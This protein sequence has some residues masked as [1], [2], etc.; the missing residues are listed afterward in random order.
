MKTTR[1]HDITLAFVIVFVAVG[2][3]AYFATNM[4]TSSKASGQNRL[5]KIKNCYSKCTYV[6][7]NAVDA[8]SCGSW[9]SRL[10][11]NASCKTCLSNCI[12]S[13]NSG[14]SGGVVQNIPIPSGINNPTVEPTTPGG[15]APKPTSCAYGTWCYNHRVVP[16]AA[17]TKKPEPSI[18]P[19]PTKK[20]TQVPMI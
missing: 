8:V 16:T 14:G 10:K 20:P 15:Q 12:V 6:P 7:D 1:E 13:V 11:A 3:V 5:T 2:M 4:L 17:P 19:N 9:E 18:K